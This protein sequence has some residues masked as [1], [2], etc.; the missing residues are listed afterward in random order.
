VIE[1]CLGFK[2]SGNFARG[3]DPIAK[4]EPGVLK[5]MWT[6]SM[7]RWFGGPAFGLGGSYF[8]LRHLI[9]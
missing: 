7:V 5:S 2:G 1:G 4:E 9:Y 8:P 6:P 3:L